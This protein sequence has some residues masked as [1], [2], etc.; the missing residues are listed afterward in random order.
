MTSQEKKQIDCYSISLRCVSCC[1]YCCGCWCCC[2]LVLLLL[3]LLLML[4]VLLTHLSFVQT[5]FDECH[6]FSRMKLNIAINI[7]NLVGGSQ[8]QQQNTH[9]S[10]LVPVC[11]F[12]EISSI[13]F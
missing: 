13:Y 5:N 6:N 3:L 11:F 10:A 9:V 7:S 4:L 1:C 2:G 8:Q 12:Q